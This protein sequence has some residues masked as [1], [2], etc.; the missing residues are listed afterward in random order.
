[1]GLIMTDRE[2]YIEKMK[3]KLDKW[4][5]DIDQLEAKGKA[6]KSD[7]QLKYSR[8]ID[9][10]KDKKKEAEAK[11][12]ELKRASEGAWD[13]LKKGVESTWDS[14]GTAVNSAISRFK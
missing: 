7:A 5:A 11:L 1:M 12:A 4:N 13:D 3:E 9:R 6:A 10:L 8:E 2:I 14:L